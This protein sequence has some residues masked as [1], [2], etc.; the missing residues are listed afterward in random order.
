MTVHP[1]ERYE[2]P[3]YF[4]QWNAKPADINTIYIDNA[5]KCLQNKYM[6]ASSVT[7]FA[8]IDKF[9]LDSQIIWHYSDTA[10]LKFVADT[11]QCSPNSDS[12]I[13]AVCISRKTHRTAPSTD[14]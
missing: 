8:T 13:Q 5:T 3:S 1:F 7:L 10:G 9:F 11:L 4:V 14:G 2:A 6:G 12:P